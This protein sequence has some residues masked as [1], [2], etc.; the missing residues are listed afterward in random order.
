[1]SIVLLGL[2]CWSSCAYYNIFWMAKSDYE[3][4]LE[5]GPYD[6]WDPYDQP[7]LKGDAQRSVDSCV[8]RCGKLLFLYPH[9]RWVDDALLIMGNCFMLKGEGQN[10]L[11]KYDEILQLYASS[12]FAPMA[13]YMKAYTLVRDG[14]VQQAIALL[15]NIVKETTHKDIRERSVFLLG[16]IAQERGECDQA[17]PYFQTYL[18]DFGK[19]TKVDAVRLHLAGCLL[20]TGEAERVIGVLEP[21][22][23]KRNPDG[24]QA[25]LKTGEAYRAMGNNDRAIEI[26]KGLT[27]EASA[28][29]VKAR[30]EMEMAKTMVARDEAKEAIP[31]LEE[32]AETATTKLGAL[33]DEIIYTEGLVY[34]KDLEDFESAV[35]AYDKIAK[36]TSE[37]GIKAKKRSEA[38]KDVGRFR[39]ALA[40][41]ALEARE[42]QAFNRFMLG[43]TYLE[44]LGLRDEAFAEFKTV[45]DSFPD[46]KVGPQAILRLAVLLEAEGDS[47]AG[48]YFRR[49][50]ELFPGTVYDNFARS[51]L[52]MPLVDVVIAKP[53][54]WEDA[55]VVGPPMPWAAAD[56]TSAAGFELPGPPLPTQERADTT[57]TA[58]SRP[59]GRP[60]PQRTS[61][62][63]DLPVIH[64]TNPARADSADTSN[65]WPGRDSTRTP[66][67]WDTAG[68]SDRY[69][70]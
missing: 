44:E 46:T 15:K 25:S 7:Q 48:D 38:L 59:P 35:G 51:H 42:D 13:R 53:E 66:A 19:G 47:S 26:F 1:M 56:T 34:E 63:A 41:T 6:F 67:P 37:Y 70:P 24:H 9:S 17:I 43:E 23:K 12:D 10:A 8:E 52:G 28:D 20:R 31:V 16:R 49:V 64:P 69:R 2:V 57:G 50:V 36:S 61:P 30:A 4:A 68:Q 22:A 60:R 33:R 55:M 3:G 11:R 54:V 39:E 32:A 58:S 14:S 29:S 27:E 18:A 45:A 40:D 65:L 62:V 21:L 5:A